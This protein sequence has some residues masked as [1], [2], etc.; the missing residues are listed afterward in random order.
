MIAVVLALALQTS[1]PLP[2]RLE[3]YFR[4]LEKAPVYVEY[5]STGL[6][7]RAP[8]ETHQLWV[9]GKAYHWD[10]FE[11][12]SDYV[13]HPVSI[14]SDGKT[15]ITLRHDEHQVRSG[16]AFG[17]MM[18][19]TRPNLYD[20]LYYGNLLG[21][22]DGYAFARPATEPSTAPGP[23]TFST[24]GDVIRM[25]SP[26]ANGETHWWEWHLEGEKLK[27]FVFGSGSESI[28]IMDVTRFDRTI[29]PPHNEFEVTPPAGYK[30]A[31]QPP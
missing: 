8:V 3:R 17:T 13:K 14:I 30:M 27:S 2:A 4:A 28:N 18:A 10:Y 31:P 5:T 11:Q 26:F 9:F 20:P 19:S 12:S 23:F 21:V 24:H 7:S 1:P 25:S 22:M 15:T 29:K 16:Q 6:N